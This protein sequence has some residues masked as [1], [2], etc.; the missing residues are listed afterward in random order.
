MGFKTTFNTFAGSLLL[1][2]FVLFSIF[3]FLEESEILFSIFVPIRIYNNADSDKSRILTDL[4]GKAGIFMWTHIETGTIYIGS[5][6]DLSKRFYQY[7]SFSYLKKTDNYI[8]P[9]GGALVLH[10]HSAFSLST[11]G[12]V[13]IKGLSQEEA[14]VLILKCEQFYLDFIFSL[15]KPNTYNIL[16]T[17]GSTLGFK[18]PPWGGNLL[19]K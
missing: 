6:I 14:R 7:Y 19:L 9:Y 2:I 4:K 15:D 11:Q 10:T 1:T 18:S 5:A 8:P 13:D 17:A 12:C 16:K 3:S